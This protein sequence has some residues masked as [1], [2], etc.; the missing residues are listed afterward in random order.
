[1]QSATKAAERGAAVTKALLAVARRQPLALGEHDLNL[2]IQEIL[3]LIRTSAGAATQV[4]LQLTRDPL[5]VRLDAGGLSSALLNLVINAREAMRDNTGPS[6]LGLL[7]QRHTDDDGNRSRGWEG[8]YAL[9]EVSDNGCGMS[10]AVR[11]QAFDPFFTTRERGHGTGLGLSTV[12]GFVHQ[13]GGTVEIDSSPGQGT[14]VRL[15]LPL[16]K[17]A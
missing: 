12:Q 7:T 4:T 17:Q 10:E 15:S 2:L 3:P 6:T 1:L 5:P 11:A 14:T 8:S 13:L 16:S 9:I